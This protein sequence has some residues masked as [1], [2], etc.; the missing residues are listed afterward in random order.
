MKYSKKIF[1]IFM[2]VNILFS[3]TF[4]YKSVEASGLAPLIPVVEGA[5]G[6]LG[7]LTL[8]GIIALII[9]IVAVEKGTELTVENW[10]TVSPAM[11][12][13]LKSVSK[14]WYDRLISEFVYVGDGVTKLSDTVASGVQ[15]NIN[16][17]YLPKT[18]IKD[19]NIDGN[20]SAEIA[21]FLADKYEFSTLAP[22]TVDANHVEIEKL[23]NSVG[24]TITANGFYDFSNIVVVKSK[25]VN[26][27]G[28]GYDVYASNSPFTINYYHSWSYDVMYLQGTTVYRYQYNQGDYWGTTYLS[29]IS[30]SKIGDQLAV[31]DNNDLSEIGINRI[32]YNSTDIAVNYTGYKTIKSKYYNYTILPSI[33]KEKYPDLSTVQALHVNS[34]LVDEMSKVHDLNDIASTDAATKVLV[35]AD[36]KARENYDTVIDKQIVDLN[37]ASNPWYDVILNPLKDFAQWLFVPD[38]TKV[39]AFVTHCQLTMDEKTSIIAYPLT[40]VIEFLTKVLSLEQTDCI[41]HIPKMELNGQVFYKG[42]DFNFTQEV[43]KTLYA[44]YY[45]T[46]LAITDF[47]MILFVINSA[48]KKG[49]EIIRGN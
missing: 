22:G 30:T 6:T 2:I 17:Y 37:P 41:L 39:D 24:V 9:S 32:M 28:Y 49:D 7:G 33:Y 1:C 8:G 18:K 14:D 38:Q 47:A 19:I 44:T 42:S 35:N 15:W 46:Y 4:N 31:S 40:L 11:L 12:A 34:Y 27:M 25:T 36:A 3:F 10:D 45:S 23:M 20:V 16:E 29:Q 13:D 48:A 5:G 43:H 26:S 21:K